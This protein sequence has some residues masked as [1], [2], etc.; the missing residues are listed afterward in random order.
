MFKQLHI[1][2][3]MAAALAF[4]IAPTLAAQAGTTVFRGVNVIPM[5]EER[6]LENQRV[7]V[8]DGRITALG[9][10]AAD[11]V[12]AGATV[13]DGSGKYLIPGYAEMHAHIPAP[14]AGSDA[15]DR[16]LYLYL[17]G[18]VTTIRGM[19]GHPSHLELRARS[20]ANEILAPRIFT[21]GPSFSGGTASDPERARAMVREQAAAGYDFLKLHP[22]LS[23]PV[24]D[25]I[26]EAANEV[27]LRV[28]GHVSADV[29]L[30]P[31]LAAGYASI[32]HLDGYVEALAGY[33]DGFPA[34][35]AGFFGFD[36]TAEAD[37]A[38]IP[39]LARATRD[40]GVW[41]VPTESLMRHLASPTPPEEMAQWPEM[42]YMPAATV[43]NWVQRK[44]AFQ[45]AEGFTPERATRY[46]ELR[47]AL[48]RSLHEAGAGL[49]LGSD[50][51]QW[52]NVPGYSARRELEYMVDAGLTPFEAL[53]M[54][55]R[56]AA[57]YFDAEG[58]W[59][60][61]A[62]GLRADL[63]LLD[64]NPLTDITNVWQQ[65]GV[66]V[67]GRW[68]PQAELQQRLDE[69]ALEVGR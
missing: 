22:G 20:A 52:W 65:A 46:I 49:I 62:P 48:I 69:I 38:L 33:R 56:D 26:I 50:A 54:G 5:D 30:G 58:E 18:G 19:L 51:P 43:A 25:A 47:A 41:N 17:A 67:G 64:A 55:T 61:I 11:A 7:V 59:G 24:F 44:Q 23:R 2:F 4:A 16:T 28:A 63:V 9:A 39:E 12:P 36:L 32:D 31:A 45:S 1:T 29:G 8:Q 6:I 40:A 66:M 53:A 37:P 68:L 35:E 60:T 13:V 21:S 34:E 14:Q 27:G 3:T 15:V 42:R 10:E 57:R